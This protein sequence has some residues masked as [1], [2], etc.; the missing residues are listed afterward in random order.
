MDSGFYAACAG[1]VARTQSLELAANNLANSSTT[2]YRRQQ[3][4]FRQV[5]AGQAPIGVLNRAVNAFGVLGNPTTDFAQGSLQKTGSPFDFAIEGRAFFA[6][7]TPAGVRYTRDGSFHLAADRTLLTAAGD[8]VLGDQG[9][10][11]LPEGEPSVSADGSVSVDGAL[12]G[13][14][15]LIE[16]APGADLVPAG[17][18]Y[19]TS[20]GAAA[21]AAKDAQVRQG[22]LENSNVRPVEAAVSLIAIQRHA[23]MLNR[24]LSI[25]HNQ[26]N[27]IAA[28]ELSRV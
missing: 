9:P 1:L 15:R 20:A 4:T 23:E 28:S 2:G 17:N 10:I 8:P 25:F 13:R 26:F 6:V 12:A 11:R 3:E 7:Q 21:G 16:F 14:L 5:F 24:T 22:M 19:Y 27:R 18:A